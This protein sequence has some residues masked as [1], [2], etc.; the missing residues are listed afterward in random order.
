MRTVVRALPPAG[1]SST[2][3]L[4]VVL[5]GAR[6][7]AVAPGR[8]ATGAGA[9]RATPDEVKLRLVRS[10]ALVRLRTVI[11]TPTSS[12]STQRAPASTRADSGSDTGTSTVVVAGPARSGTP[13]TPTRQVVSRSPSGISMR[14]RPR[15]SVRTGGDQ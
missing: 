10:A 15:A 9:K 8:A 5:A 14:T 2:T 13:T 7:G 3:S 11:A 6:G 4:P 12:P 1:T